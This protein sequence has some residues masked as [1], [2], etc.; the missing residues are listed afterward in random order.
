M[1]PADPTQAPLPDDEPFDPDDDLDA[2]PMRAL[3]KRA[4]PALTP[5][6]E[7]RML[8]Q[9]QRKLRARSNGKFYGDGWSTAQG[10]I[11]YALIAMT[12]LVLVALAYLALGPTGM[13]R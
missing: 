5:L 3:L 8:A 4:A 11:S 7:K 10:R 12:M 2:D 13:S 6:P 1:S 9:V